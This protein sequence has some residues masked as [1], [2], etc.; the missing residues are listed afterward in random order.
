VRI[1]L[2]T[3]KD[4]EPRLEPSSEYVQ[5]LRGRVG[6]DAEVSEFVA[7]VEVPVR[8]ET[9]NVL[10]LVD[11]MWDTPRRGSGGRDRLIELVDVGLVQAERVGKELAVAVVYRSGARA[12]AEV[13]RRINDLRSAEVLRAELPWLTSVP[14]VR[15]RELAWQQLATIWRNERRNLKLSGEP[16][17]GFLAHMERLGIA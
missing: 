13:S 1:S 9:R 7:A 5:H 16:V 15:F 3:G 8:I 4:V 10:V 11:T 12:A 17:K 14:E 2:W 6:E